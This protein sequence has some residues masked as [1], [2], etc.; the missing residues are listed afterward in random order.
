MYLRPQLIIPKNE[1]F[2]DIERDEGVDR[3][4]SDPPSDT[5]LDQLI[6]DDLLQMRRMAR[7]RD[8][9]NCF[10]GLVAVVA[11]IFLYLLLLFPGVFVKDISRPR[12][13]T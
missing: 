6:V 2:S 12:L 8:I 1:D 4:S 3:K 13:R 10:Q 7:R 5:D 11:L 9:I